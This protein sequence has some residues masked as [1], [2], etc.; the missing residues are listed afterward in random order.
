MYIDGVL[1][2]TIP[3]VTTMTNMALAIGK[4]S[5]TQYRNGNIDEVKI[6]N[7]PISATQV[8]NLY[9]IKPSFTGA[10]RTIPLGNTVTLT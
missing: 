6:Y 2:Q 1:E 9:M 4:Y 8:Q 3:A 5:T 10:T 7:T